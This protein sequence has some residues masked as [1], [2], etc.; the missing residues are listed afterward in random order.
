MLLGDWLEEKPFT[1]ALS[2]GFFAFFAH[3]GMLE[4]LLASGLRPGR[5]TGASAGALVGGCWA[6]GVPVATMRDVL[7]N[8][9]RDAFWDPA[10]GLGLLR[11]ARFRGLL[12]RLTGNPDMQDLPT[13]AAI[14]VWRLRDRRT[15]VISEGPLVSAISASCAVPMLFHPVT[16]TGALCWDGGIADRHGLAGC[17]PAERVLYHHILSR[18]PWRRRNSTALVV[19]QREELSALVLEGLPRSGPMRL[20]QGRQAMEMARAATRRA[21]DRPLC[22]GTVQERVHQDAAS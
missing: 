7:E 22:A 9:E 11:G 6:A 20:D 18:S 5:V 19:P 17:G 10:P 8:L 4:A 14:S 12:E 16:V 21:L 1:L 15:R 2:S 13:P 3:L